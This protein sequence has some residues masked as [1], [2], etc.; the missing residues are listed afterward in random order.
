M[1]VCLFMKGPLTIKWQNS[2]WSFT[3]NFNNIPCLGMGSGKF[4]E[5]LQFVQDF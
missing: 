3:C 5:L 1:G 4:D 2:T